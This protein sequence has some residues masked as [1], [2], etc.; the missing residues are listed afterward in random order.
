MHIL[1]AALSAFVV[2]FLSA[3]PSNGQSTAGL[4]TGAKK[5]RLTTRIIA[6]ED[7]SDAS[8]FCAVSI[9]DI[10]HS[11]RSILDKSRITLTDKGYDISIIVGVELYYMDLDEPVSIC[12]A[13]VSVRSGISTEI[14][15]PHANISAKKWVDLFERA[16]TVVDTRSGFVI[17][18]SNRLTGI[19]KSFVDT[20]TKDQRP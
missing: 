4:F 11:A 19:M 20:W 16:N 17:E 2:M 10:E 8:S 9:D 14:H 18:I 3:T 6:P 1:V 15:L 12:A 13:R 7:Q 5:A